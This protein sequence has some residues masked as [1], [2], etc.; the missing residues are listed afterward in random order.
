MVGI[1]GRRWASVVV[2]GNR[3]SGARLQHVEEICG[4]RTAVRAVLPWTLVRGGLS[5]SASH[6]LSAVPHTTC[7]AIALQDE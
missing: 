1:G 4:Y 2:R 7:A 6:C 3:R 5:T